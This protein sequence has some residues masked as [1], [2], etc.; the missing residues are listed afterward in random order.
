MRAVC[1]FKRGD[2]TRLFEIMRDGKKEG[3]IVIFVSQR[4]KEVFEITDRCLVLRDGKL[5]GEVKTED[6]A[7]EEH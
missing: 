3:R 4:L 6:I 5:T 7:E 2:V 1:L